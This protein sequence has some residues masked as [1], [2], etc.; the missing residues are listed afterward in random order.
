MNTIK[1][2]PYCCTLQEWLECNYGVRM[3]GVPFMA[4]KS[5]EQMERAYKVLKKRHPG[6]HWTMTNKTKGVY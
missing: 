1:N 2:K 3:D 5:W 4:C 6:A